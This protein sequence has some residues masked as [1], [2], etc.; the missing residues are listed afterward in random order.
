M[1]PTWILSLPEYV[2]VAARADGEVALL[3]LRSPVTLRE[4][5]PGLSAALSR[6][7]APGDSAGRLADHVRTMDGP[8]ALALWYYHLQTLARRCLLRLT[9]HVG[10][11]RLATLEPIA[12]SFVLPATGV[13]PGRSYVLSRFAW[14]QRRGDELTLESPLSP[15]RILLHDP[16]AV[17]LVHALAQPGPAVEIAGRV[18]GLLAE[19]VAPLLGLLA[20]AGAV[21]TVGEDGLTAEDADP[22]QRCWEFHDLLFH[23]RSRQGRHDAPAGRYLSA[24]RTTRPAAS[25]SAGDGSGWHRP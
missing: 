9:V 24:R 22:A 12:P 21:C 7:A 18:A 14:V 2:T 1:E 17:A 8:A 19:T 16:R 5:S 25:H 20:H 11:E 15:A 23:A 3:G 10:G 6:L 13:L 4:L